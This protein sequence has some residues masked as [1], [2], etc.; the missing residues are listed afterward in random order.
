MTLRRL[1]NDEDSCCSRDCS[2]HRRSTPASETLSTSDGSLRAVSLIG[3]AYSTSSFFR[4][5]VHT[6]LRGLISEPACVL[7][8]TS[9]AETGPSSCGMRTT[10]RGQ[11]VASP[12]QTM[13]PTRRRSMEQAQPNIH[14]ENH[15]MESALHRF[16]L[17]ADC[18]VIAL[19]PACEN[20]D[21]RL[22]RWN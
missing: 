18:L 7:R 16:L 9:P 21:V 6:S 14:P 22:R 4:S 5:I 13:K 19:E 8:W 11:C 15:S 12:W 17:R 20:G 3:N 1:E 2:I 10:D